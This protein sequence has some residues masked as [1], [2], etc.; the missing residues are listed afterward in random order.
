MIRRLI[1]ALWPVS[2]VGSDRYGWCAKFPWDKN[3]V[4]ASNREI[5]ISECRRRYKDGAK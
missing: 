2:V 1:A 4:F 3:Y 5:A